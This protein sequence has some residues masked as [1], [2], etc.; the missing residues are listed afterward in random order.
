[1]SEASSHPPTAAV[2]PGAAPAGL[3]ENKGIKFHIK[4]GNST[5]RCTLQDRSH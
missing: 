1:M 4:T 2:V 3:G 5:W